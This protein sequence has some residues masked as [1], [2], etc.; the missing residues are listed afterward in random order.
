MLSSHPTNRFFYV[1][2]C[3]LTSPNADFSNSNKG[4]QRE[5]RKYGKKIKRGTGREN[6]SFALL[7]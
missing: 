1:V 2:F 6:A 3:F 5:K 7:V 4:N